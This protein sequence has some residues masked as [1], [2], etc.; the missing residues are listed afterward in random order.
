MRAA[1]AAGA[2]K[3]VAIFIISLLIPIQI[4]LGGIRLSFYRV[5]LLLALVPIVLRLTSSLPIRWRLADILVIVFSLT[6]S[7]ALFMTGASVAAI[8][9]FALESFGPYFL[10]RAFI[11]NGLQFSA[12]ARTLAACI[13]VTIPFAL[14]ENVTR[15]P[16]ILT[17]LGKV[18]PVLPD[19]PH[20]QRLGLDRAQVTFD[21][22]ILYGVFCAFGFAVAIYA[23]RPGPPP[24]LSLVRGALVGLAAFLSLSSGALVAVGLQGALIVYD[25]VLGSFRQRWTLMASGFG[26][27]Y[28]VLEAFSNRSMAQIMVPYLAMNPGNAYTRIV[29]NDWAISGILTQPWFGFGFNDT[30]PVPFWVVTTSI[31]NFWL[32]LAFRHGIPTVFFLL[33]TVAAVLLSV[34][35]TRQTDPFVNA[36]RTG[37]VITMTGICVSVI[38]VHLWNSTYVAFMFLLGSAMWLTERQEETAETAEDAPGAPS[39]KPRVRF[40]RDL[41]GPAYTRQRSSARNE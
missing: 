4:H 17:V 37:F 33:A 15:N 18:L 10:A 31:D 36:C 29:V 9:I 26:T 6:G 22:P 24:R 23:A 34:I 16:I 19:V 38:T 2:T 21:H 3:W 12:M 20:E 32:A 28:L 35:F 25:R 7:L 11:R 14:F 27:L 39:A 1:P 30:W 13:I 41:G 40:R 5:A 8:G